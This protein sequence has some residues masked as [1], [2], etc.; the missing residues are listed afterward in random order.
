[1]AADGTGAPI[2][3]SGTIQWVSPDQTVGQVLVD[4]LRV[5][6]RFIPRDFRLREVQKGQALPEFHVVF[7]YLGPFADP[8]RRTGFR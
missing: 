8:P 3:Y 7:S 4:R 2:A 5:P 6:I 1:M